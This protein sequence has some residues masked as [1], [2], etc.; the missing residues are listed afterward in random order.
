[1]ALEE[2]AIGTGTEFK[3][4]KA[5]YKVADTTFECFKQHVHGTQTL[6]EVL[7]NSCNQGMVQISRAID[8][9]T[10]LRYQAAYGVG[11][12]TGIDLAGEVSAEGLVYT[13]DTL[14]PVERATCSFGQGFNMTPIQLITAFAAAVNG[15]EYLQPYVVS[16]VTD[17][18]GNVVLSNSKT[19]LRHTVSEETSR[20]LRPILQDQI[21][22]NLV[23]VSHIYS[24]PGYTFGGKTGTAQQEDYGKT[25]DIV[26]FV[27][28]T[29]VDDPE[30]I[31]LV[32]L[33]Q[34]D[35]AESLHACQ[36]SFNIMQKILPVLEIYPEK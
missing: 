11:Q 1:M 26:S 25:K 4:V 6:R 10:Y 33:S 30:I 31:L 13:K 17:A 22:E 9:D 21:T 32:V 27:A 35:N 2:S 23:K 12:L 34:D 5:G 24:L 36:T 29:P 3:C 18:K 15:G 7:I 28:F 14:G 16:Q 20:A 8:S 19:V